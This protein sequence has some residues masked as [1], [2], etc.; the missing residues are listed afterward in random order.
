[1]EGTVFP[2]P[3]QMGTHPTLARGMSV[4]SSGRVPNHPHVLIWISLTSP[5]TC[6]RASH[7]RCPEPFSAAGQGQTLPEVEVGVRVQRLPAAG[8]GASPSLLGWVHR[9]AGPSPA[10]RE[11]ELETAH[12]HSP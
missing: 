9:A 3:E 4:A 10:Q 2:G 5:C 11:R 1:M 6:V 7:V 12:A 8:R